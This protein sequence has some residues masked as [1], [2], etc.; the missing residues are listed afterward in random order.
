MTKDK[1]TEIVQHTDV[2]EGFWQKYIQK[3]NKQS[4]PKGFFLKRREAKSL[5]GT[6]VGDLSVD[7]KLALGFFVSP[8]EMKDFEATLPAAQAP[9]GYYSRFAVPQLPQGVAGAWGAGAGVGGANANAFA[10]PGAGSSGFA[11]L[12]QSGGQG[13]QFGAQPGGFTQSGANDAQEGVE[14]AQIVE[15]VV[16]EGGV[17]PAQFGADAGVG[18]ANANAFAQPGAGGSGFASLTQSGAQGGAQPE[19]FAQPPAKG[20]A[21][22]QSDVASAETPPPPEQDAQFGADASASALPPAPSETPPPKKR[23]S[24]PKS[25]GNAAGHWGAMPAEPAP[26]PEEEAHLQSSNSAAQEIRDLRAQMKFTIENHQVEMAEKDLKIKQL[27]ERIADFHARV[28]DMSK[29]IE[30]MTNRIISHGSEA[31]STES[32]AKAVFEILGTGHQSY[33]AD[34][35]NLQ[36][37]VEDIFHHRFDDVAHEHSSGAENG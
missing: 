11:P 18:G 22:A 26:E 13:V 16:A 32:K 20:G 8:Q 31:L 23:Y 4:K 3:A 10:Q 9:N 19:D 7:E 25:S 24:L 37:V 33:F 6:K 30:K 12:T 34:N 1:S 2:R 35:S 27:N 15:D 21:S 5:K 29:V 14:E 28:N 36:K 17:S